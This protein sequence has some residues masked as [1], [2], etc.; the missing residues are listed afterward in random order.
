MEDRGKISQGGLGLI[1]IQVIENS[2]H[3]REQASKIWHAIMLDVC[4]VLMPI[5]CWIM[6]IITLPSIVVASNRAIHLAK[7]TR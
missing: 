5:L 4:T 3:G 7:D 1:L 2:G 6:P